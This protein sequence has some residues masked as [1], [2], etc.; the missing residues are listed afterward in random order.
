MCCGRSVNL[1]YHMTDQPPVKGNPDTFNSANPYTLSNISAEVKC[2]SDVNDASWVH[3][4][5]RPRYTGMPL[6]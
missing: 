6:F 1:K 3:N 5:T 2:K 4:H